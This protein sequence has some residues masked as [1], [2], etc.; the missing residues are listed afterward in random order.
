LADTPNGNLIDRFL[1]KMKSPGVAR[2]FL[3]ELNCS[4]TGSAAAPHGLEHH[5]SARAHDALPLGDATRP[6]VHGKARG[7]DAPLAP[8]DPAARPPDALAHSAAGDLY[9]RRRRLQAGIGHARGGRHCSCNNA[10]EQGGRDNGCRDEF[11]F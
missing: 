5:R 6:R 11:H 4:R 9:G 7:A 3:V 10:A 8:D 1:Q 2:R